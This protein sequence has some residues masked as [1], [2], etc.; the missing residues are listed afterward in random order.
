MH[1]EEGFAATTRRLLHYLLEDPESAARKRVDIALSAMVLLSV[2]VWIRLSDPLITDQNRLALQQLQLL[3]VILFSLEYFCRLWLSSPFWPDCLNAYQRSR[4]RR[5]ATLFV[6]IGYAL[7]KALYNKLLWIIKPLSVIDLIACMPVLQIFRDIPIL[8]ILCLLKVFR[9][10]RHLAALKKTIP[11][12]FLELLP[13][14]VSTVL[15]WSLVAIAFYVVEKESNPRLI[16]LWDAFYWM[17]VTVT[18]VGYGDIVPST[19]SGQFVAMAGVLTG[20]AITTSITLILVSSITNR[21]LLMRESR[22]E[23]RID[24]L[25]KYYIICGLSEMGRIVCN[26]MTTEKK[27]F[28][29]ID[30]QPDRVE[31]ARRQGWLALHGSLQDEETW[32]RLNLGKAVA[33]IITLHDEITTISITLIVRE[34]SRHCN[35]VACASNPAA[36]KQLLKLGVNRVV[37]PIR[38]SG[39]QMTHSA[40][41][42]TAVHFLDRILTTEFAD[43]EM[44]EFTLPPLSIFEECALQ[45]TNIRNKFNIIV[46]GIQP[47]RGIMHFNPRADVILRP[48]DT[49][50]CLGHKDDINRLRETVLSETY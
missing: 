48:G 43:M 15:L 10:S 17:F 4:R 28:V 8:G 35:I 50:L 44:D 49:L 47:K 39:L 42:P 1:G 45:E 27:P 31:A 9:Y 26:N 2:M 24:Q 40:L 20:I 19:T 29:A 13:V 6:A 38:V 18:S 33:V 25:N 14:L 23:Y 3:C 32:N 22:I 11:G 5:H 30:H 37:S 46:V 12:H 7:K 16:S 41:R 36:E 21:I 34:R